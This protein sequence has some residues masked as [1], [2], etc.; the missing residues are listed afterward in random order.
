MVSDRQNKRRKK[1]SEENKPVEQDDKREPD[2]E[3]QYRC[4]MSCKADG[5]LSTGGTQFWALRS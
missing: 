5:G 3:A 4:G 1:M 2:A